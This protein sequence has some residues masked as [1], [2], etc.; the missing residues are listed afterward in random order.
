MPDRN[1]HFYTTISEYQYLD[2]I[3]LFF[4]LRH[5]DLNQI[6]ETYKVY[7]CIFH[8]WKLENETG[9]ELSSRTLCGFLS[10]YYMYMM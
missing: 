5:T 6:V 8:V 3:I 4:L 10:V 2:F 1:L 9:S 7:L